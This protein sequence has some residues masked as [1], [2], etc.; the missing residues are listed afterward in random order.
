MNTIVHIITRMDMGGSAQNTLKT[1]AGLSGKKYRI[2]LICGA[3]QE[4]KMTIAEMRTVAVNLD[5]A[6]KQGLKDFVL[7]TLIRRI[8]PFM[9]TLALVDLIRLIRR[10]RPEIVHTHTSKAGILGRLAAWLL[11][12]PVIVHTPHGH[13][14]HGHF[15]RLLSKTFLFIERIF[16]KITD[17]TIALTDGERDDYIKKS[18]SKPAKL[19]KIHSGVDI[20]KFMQQGSDGYPLR[21]SKGIGDTDRVVGMVGWL[22]PIKG[23]AYLLKAMQIVWLKHPDVKLIFVGKGE[24]E[25]E[26]KKRAADSGYQDRVRFLGWRDDIH[27]IMSVFDI[28]VLPSLNEGMGRVIVEAMAAGKP[29]IAS[30][31]GGIPDLVVEGETGL[32][33]DPGDSDGLAEA[34]STL[35]DNSTLRKAMGREG[36]NRCHQFSEELMI[37]KIDQLYQKLLA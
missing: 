11:R 3:S 21:E 23:P 36:R 20:Q 19:V 10:E 29:V 33:V 16:D 25:V 37:E 34:I 35:L 5:A 22:I 31:T 8:D 12:V 17:R 15:S 32:L 9:D 1:C 30:N 24:L 28:F 26:L 7:P 6:A 27:E 4:S 14:F 18:V 13:V 2:V